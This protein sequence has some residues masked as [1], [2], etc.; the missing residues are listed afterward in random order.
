MGLAPKAL[1][2]QEALW[3]HLTLTSVPQPPPSSVK[4]KDTHLYY[5]KAIFM[6][7]AIAAVMIC[8]LTKY[9]VSRWNT[10]AKKKKKKTWFFYENKIEYFGKTT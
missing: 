8:D 3:A 10:S 4:H 7:F 5:S 6:L 9:C 2:A 1:V